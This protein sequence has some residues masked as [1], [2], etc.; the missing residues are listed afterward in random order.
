MHSKLRFRLPSQHRFSA[1]LGM[2]L[3]IVGLACGTA[4]RASDSPSITAEPFLD[5]PVVVGASESGSNIASG[6]NQDTGE[7]EGIFNKSKVPMVDVSKA[8]VPL[9]DIVFDT[10][11]RYRARFLPLDTIEEDVILELRD[12]IAPIYNPVYGGPDSLDWLSDYD[13]V[14]G[15][16]SGDDAYAY[17]VN[18]LNLH[19]LVNDEIDGVSLLI[20]YCPLC[21]SGV[22]FDRN[23]DGEVLLFG[24]TSAL[25]QSDLVMYDHQTG[26]YWF[27]LAGE[28][29]VGELT[30]A[31]LDLLP[32]MTMAW[33]DWK[34]LYPDTRLLVGVGSSPTR[35]S[36]RR[37]GQGFS[38]GYKERINE[39]EFIFPVD[40]EKL[41]QRLKSGDLVLTIEV[42]DAVTAYPLDRIGRVALNDEVGGLPVV[43]FNSVKGQSVGAFFRDVDGQVLTFEYRE[44]SEAFIDRETGSVWDLAGRAVEGPLAG[45]ELERAST[46][47]GFWFSIAIT[48]PNVELYTP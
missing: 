34:A 12:A 17:P 40:R 38:G 25:Y 20:S 28:A 33:K 37:Y 13:L 18:I 24:N 8:S 16:V 7:A 9:G 31:R 36:G 30:G 39:N 11:G 23:L 4:D 29:V 10:F 1:L 43:V 45:A 22:T 14:M 41:D 35:F 5:V 32:S 6:E 47:R 46:R 44:E 26:S 15:Y 42:N 3:I 21:V 27:Q 19:E 48:F 2:G